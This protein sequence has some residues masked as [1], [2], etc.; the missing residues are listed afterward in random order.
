MSD[1]DNIKERAINAINEDTSKSINSGFEYEIKGDLLHFSY[2]VYDQ[3]NYADVCNVLESIPNTEITWHGYTLDG[4]RVELVF[5][6]KDFLD[7]YYHGAL[8]SKSNKIQQGNRRK[9]EIRKCTSY[10]Q[11]KK[12]LIKWK[13]DND[14]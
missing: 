5:N 14:I 10:Q 9:K 2:D 6:N 4:N 8:I 3:I 12:L 11:I 1:L 7:L 13:I